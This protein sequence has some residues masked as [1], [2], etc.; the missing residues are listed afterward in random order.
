[1][2]VQSMCVALAGDDVVISFAQSDLDAVGAYS[3]GVRVNILEENIFQYLT[4]LPEDLKE[5]TAWS[6]S[7]SA[8]SL[9]IIQKHV[10]VLW[11]K[12]ILI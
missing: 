9:F 3:G 10:C 1:M 5:L 6:K 12:W 11:M 4:L 7:G 2:S 8:L